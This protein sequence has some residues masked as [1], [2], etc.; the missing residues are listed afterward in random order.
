MT[1]VAMTDDDV[2]AALLCSRGRLRPRADTMQWY[3]M[4]DRHRKHV[5]RRAVLDAIMRMTAF[6][7][8]FDDVM[9][10]ERLFYAINRI[11][12]PL[13]CKHCGVRRLVP[14]HV[15][16]VAKLSKTCH[17]SVCVNKLKGECS[18]A[19]HTN[20]S[21]EKRSRRG[22]AISR[23]TKGISWD[24]RY[25]HERAAEMRHAMRLAK[26]GKKQSEATRL[27]R[28]K[29]LKGRKFSPDTR[30]KLS[31]SNKARH[32]D[33]EFRK[34]HASRL[35]TAAPKISRKLKARIQDGTF[36]PCITNSWT[37]C[38]VRVIVDGI[39]HAFRS[40]FEAA[41]WLLN[42]HLAYETVRIPYEYDGSWHTYIVDFEDKRA[43]IVYE[44]KPTSMLDEPRNIAKFVAAS[45]WAHENGYR[46]VIVDNAWFASNAS[47]IDYD[48]H[49][50]VLKGM[51]Q[52]L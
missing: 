42:Q 51:R 21:D 52:F 22:E 34:L 8:V 2:I 9:L 16:N 49:A 32:S 43:K 10:R 37:H 48:K 6:L 19:M 27:K 5:N 13:L 7:D 26:L 12:K 31:A 20:M 1:C 45:K 35:V 38:D 25:G 47:G 50:C 28:S 17:V 18:Y 15:T 24:E 33:P 46:F 11:D 39:E 4:R 30:A 14:R 36:T 23:A 29:S 44:V 40:T 3:H 41:F